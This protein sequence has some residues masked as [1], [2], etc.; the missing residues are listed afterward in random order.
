M[1]KQEKPNT[2]SYDY[3]P[4]NDTGDD[5]FNPVDDTINEKVVLPTLKPD[6]NGGYLFPNPPD[7]S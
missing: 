7:Q 2:I 4:Q 6:G 5:S 3:S 1:L